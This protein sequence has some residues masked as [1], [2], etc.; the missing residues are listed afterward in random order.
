MLLEFIIG[1]EFFTHL[2]K[3]GKFANDHTRFYAAQITLVFEHLHNDSVL[4]RDLKPENLLLDAIGN[5]KITDFGF[6]KKVEDRTWTLCGTPECGGGNEASRAPPA[7]ARHCRVPRARDHP[8]QGPRQ[9]GRLVARSA[10]ARVR[11]ARRL[12]AVLRPHEAAR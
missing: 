5:C 4:Y 2:R 7:R 3:A 1:G 10:S 6:A 11:D 8:E 9:V 12:P